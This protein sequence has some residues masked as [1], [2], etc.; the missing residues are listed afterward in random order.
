MYI[1]KIKDKDFEIKLDRQ[2]ITMNGTPFEWD[3][4]KTG[5]NSYHIIKDDVSY[6][7]EIVH[8]NEEE[9]NAEIKVNGATVNVN[10]KNKLDLLLKELGMDKLASTKV[11]DVKAPMPG[12]ILSMSVAEGDEVKK[13]DPLF[14]LE[15]MKMENV[16]KSPSDGIIQSIKAAQGDSVEKNEVLIQF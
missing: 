8:W 16:I 10:V 7:V 1:A 13:G 2:G 15:A 12:L 9:K 6:N 14:I 3:M 5:D 4:T 11:N